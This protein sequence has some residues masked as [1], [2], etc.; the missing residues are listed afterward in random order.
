MMDPN[1]AAALYWGGGAGFPGHFPPRMYPGGGFYAPGP[2]G[3]IPTQRFG[4][5]PAPMP[6][7]YA[8]APGGVPMPL[9]VQ[10]PPG[11]ERNAPHG[12]AH[13]HPHARS[14]PHPHAHTHPHVH[15]TPHHPLIMPFAPP[16]FMPIGG[17]VAAAAAPPP[18]AGATEPPASA[19]PSPEPPPIFSQQALE[20]HAKEM[21]KKMQKRAANRRSAQLSR[22]RKKAFISELKIQNEQLRRHEEIL[23]VVPDPVFAFNALD[24]QIWFA[25]NTALVQFG[26]E[27]SKILQYSFFDIVSADCANRLKALIQMAMEEVATGDTILLQERMTVRFL[28]L[29]NL[30][31]KKHEPHDTA[32][33]GGGSCADVDGTQPTASI[34]SETDKDSN[35]NGDKDSSGCG[36]AS[37]SNGDKDSSGSGGDK[38]SSGSGGDKDSSGGDKDSSGSGGDN[39]AGDNATGDKDS[40]TGD[41]DSSTGS[42]N[43]DPSKQ[44]AAQKKF[45]VLG[46]LSGRLSRVEGFTCICSIRLMHTWGERAGTGAPNDNLLHM[47]SHVVAGKRK[48]SRPRD[49]PNA[50]YNGDLSTS[51]LDNESVGTLSS[52]YSASGSVLG[53]PS[54]QSSV[55]NSGS[56]S[57]SGVG[58]GAG[59]GSGS[60]SGTAS[61]SGSGVTTGSGSGDQNNTFA[62]PPPAAV[63]ITA[64]ASG[65]TIKSQAQQSAV[66]MLVD[67]SQKR[68]SEP[69]PSHR[70]KRGHKGSPPRLRGVLNSEP[71]QDGYEESVSSGGHDGDEENITDSEGS[72]ESFCG[73]KGPVG[74]PSSSASQVNEDDSTNTHTH[75]TAAATVGAAAAPLPPSSS[76]HHHR[77]HHHNHHHHSHHH[78]Y[79]NAAPATETAAPQTAAPDEA[80]KSNGSGSQ[81]PEKRRHEDADSQKKRSRTQPD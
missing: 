46:E 14:H 50:G 10:V 68:S 13:S 27:E 57:G 6:M 24:G 69:C 17:V 37:A 16:S 31:P 54:A 74:L 35:S 48:S 2:F 53:V 67:S 79:T 1:I 40:S 65:A 56:A 15:H 47:P 80:R 43:G 77:H 60:G 29:S 36:S 42:T 59:S 30:P 11:L 76:T 34:R 61:G 70:E 55:S 18:G 78:N 25:S 62:A 20:E 81:R 51:E 9:P 4:T 7:F 38:D 58:S 3:A 66:P 8:A 71:Q 52:I 19:A 45:S 39:A 64:A 75:T 26:F 49:V 12:H 32:V 73:A 28:D 72:N 23:E 63:T 22:K 21:E 44:A 5:P 41:K 33:R